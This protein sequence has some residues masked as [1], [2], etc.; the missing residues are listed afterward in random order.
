MYE[1][2]NTKSKNLLW[3]LTAIDEAKEATAGMLAEQTGL[4]SATISRGLSALK[5]RK[6]ITQSSKDTVELGRKPDVFSIHASYG[7]ILYFCLE[8]GMLHGYLINFSGKV[9]A[10]CSEPADSSTTVQTFLKKIIQLKTLLL[11]GKKRAADRLLAVNLAIP[12]LRDVSSGVIHRIPNYPH[13]ENMDL[14]S[15][16]EETLGLKCFVHN[17]SRL[18]AIGEYLSEGRQNPNLIYLDITS[19]CGIGA[20]II[21]GGALYKD[22]SCIAGEVGDMVISPGT[23]SWDGPNSQG[24]L[25]R[26]AGLHSVFKEATALMAHGC[27]PELSKLLPAQD[28]RID[29]SMLEK[30]ALAMDIDI[31]DLLNRTTK[32]WAAAVVNICALLAPDEVVIGGAVHSGNLLVEKMIKHHIKRIYYRP[33]NLRF[34]K[35]DAGAHVLGAAYLSKQ[36]LF[37]TAVEGLQDT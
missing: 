2:N 15:R 9:A 34:A 12:G 26:S 17:I 7:Y 35:K 36:Y 21:L 16:V 6:I 29:L 20:G 14:A 33:V 32:A 11:T 19:D 22:R 31:Y 5:S 8:S 18:T 37:E 25:E 4:S 28:S 1:T 27:T 3:I 10:K 23:D 30:A 24:E 13:F